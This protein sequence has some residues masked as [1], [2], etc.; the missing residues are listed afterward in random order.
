ML[1]RSD[2]TVSHLREVQG[3]GE[4]EGSRPEQT[5][6]PVGARA[7]TR[8]APL[9]AVEGKTQAWQTPGHVS[10][11]PKSESLQFP[12]SPTRPGL[13]H[14]RRPVPLLLTPLF[15]CPV[16]LPKRSSPRA[17]WLPPH[18]LRTSDRCHLLREPSSATLFTISSSFLPSQSSGLRPVWRKS[19]VLG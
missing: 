2:S 3:C 11:G 6:L 8:G 1:K 10:L 18:L 19:R 14:P 9:P 17:T 16:L 13:Q 15:S 5:L 7:V 12:L 4:A